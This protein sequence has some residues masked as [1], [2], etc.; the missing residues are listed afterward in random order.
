[1]SKLIYNVFNTATNQTETKSVLVNKKNKELVKKG[2]KTERNEI[3][4]M[5]RRLFTYTFLDLNRTYLNNEFKVNVRVE[6]ATRRPGVTKGFKQKIDLLL[7][8]SKGLTYAINFANTSFS[9]IDPVDTAARSNHIYKTFRGR[10]YTFTFTDFM[11]VALK[12]TKYAHEVLDVLNELKEI[13]FFSSKVTMP[14]MQQVRNCLDNAADRVIME[15]EIV[16][17]AR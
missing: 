1:M 2:I 16:E 4:R 12:T 13:K 9:Q 6:M 14:T 15:D 8:N 17:V 10:A 11:D 7:T 5:T 3:M